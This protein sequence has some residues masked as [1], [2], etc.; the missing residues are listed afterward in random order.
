MLIH[1]TTEVGYRFEM[2]D[3]TTD[4]P[5]SFYLDVSSDIVKVPTQFFGGDYISVTQIDDKLLT[6]YEVMARKDVF[7]VSD[8]DRICEVL[9][10]KAKGNSDY[11]R[12]RDCVS[13]S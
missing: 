8:Y 3:R 4:M 12:V 11:E 5:S 2:L 9:Q 7:D 10:Y 6:P 1:G 13:G